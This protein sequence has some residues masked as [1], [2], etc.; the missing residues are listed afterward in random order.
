MRIVVATER[1]CAGGKLLLVIQRGAEIC[2]R[3]PLV[4]VLQ[5][6]FRVIVDDTG[7]IAQHF[8]VSTL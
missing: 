5:N 4:G 2:N 6:I 7:L 8:V 1:N 3:F